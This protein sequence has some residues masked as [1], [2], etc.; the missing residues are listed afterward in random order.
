MGAWGTGLYQDDVTCD[1]KEDYL[2]RLRIGYSNEEATEEVIEMNSDF[3]EDEED[4]PLFWLALAD[5]QWKYGRLVPKVKREALRSIKEGKDLERWKDDKKNYE[6][7]K[8]V[9]KK[10]EEQLNSPQPPEKKVKS[11]SLHKAEWEVGDVLLYKIK[12]DEMRQHKYYNKYVLLRVVGICKLNIGSL[13][14]EYSHEQN[15]VALYNWVGDAEPDLKKVNEL[16]FA[17]EKKVG[18][19]L[20]NKETLEH[21]AIERVVDKQFSLYLNK[22]EFKKLDFKV[23]MK[24]PKYKDPNEH[25]MTGVGIDWLNVHNMEFVFVDSLENACNKDSLVCDIE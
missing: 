24:D 15:I 8:T 12:S 10:I 16:S 6:K 18:Y 1:V 22:R 3:I 11:L 21:V 13:P 25:I 5:T 23:I 9:L 2:D 7:R 19:R 20:V 4:G 17:T 14:K